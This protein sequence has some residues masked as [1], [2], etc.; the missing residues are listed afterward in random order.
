MTTLTLQ[1][2]DALMEK[3]QAIAKSKE[4][5]LDE[6]VVDLLKSAVQQNQGLERSESPEERGQR[7]DELLAKFGRYD[8]GGPFTRD[9]LNER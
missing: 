2:E 5:S 4:A 1:V 9:E 8:T 6:Y 3:T 7:W